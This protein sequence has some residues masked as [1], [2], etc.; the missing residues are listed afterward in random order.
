MRLRLLG[1]A[2]GGGVPQW[3]CRFT[4]CQ[5]ARQGLIAPRASCSLAFSPGGVS[6]YL[7]NATPEVSQQIAR[8]PE[9][10]PPSG[11]RSTPLH[12]VLLTDGELDHVLGLLELR[13][14]ARWTLYATTP[15]TQL[16]EED[17]R[18]LPALRRYAGVQGRELSLEEALY[19]GDGTSQV[20]V[21]VVETG[22]RL[23]RYLGV[24]E[25]ASAGA[26]VAVVLTD[27]ATGKRAVYAPGVGRLSDALAQ[28]CRGAD[29]IFFDGTFWTEDELRRLGITND[30]AADM[31]H[32]PVSGP[33]GS[34][35][36]LAEVAAHAKLYVHINNTNP[37]L[38]PAS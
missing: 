15:V 4:N 38:D 24:A 14:D 21:R 19:L 6:W 29:V 12:G 32:V 23:P 2:A 36:W 22:R 7:I 5:A 1:T 33:D 20:E 28:E 27:L 11:I 34:A 30:R 25:R 18:V 3:N 37:L 10:Q 9:L 31:G 17:L 35:R 16:L 13:Q 8:W 26:V